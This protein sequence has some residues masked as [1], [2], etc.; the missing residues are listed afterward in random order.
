MLNFTKFLAYIFTYLTIQGIC[1]FFHTEKSG[2][3]TF[4][5]KNAFFHNNNSKL[6]WR[7]YNKKAKMKL[8]NRLK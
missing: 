4:L 8:E 1:A 3:K 7:I 2:N 6:V 5:C